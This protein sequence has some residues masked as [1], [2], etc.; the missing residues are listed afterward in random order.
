[1]LA[2]DVFVYC[3]DLAPIAAAVARVMAP[4][5]LFAFTVESHDGSGILLQPTL[6]YAHGAA[7]V[8]S[9]IEA[10]GL[11]LRHLEP[12]STR[13][14]KGEWVPGLVAVAMAPPLSSP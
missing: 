12:V 13:K 4:G 10:A 9:A 14:E 7:H 2:A 8:R 6:R 3:G 1:M 11:Q 5:G